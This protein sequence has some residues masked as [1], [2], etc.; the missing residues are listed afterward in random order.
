[1]ADDFAAG[2]HPHYAGVITI[3]APPGVKPRI[4]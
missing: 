4:S 1:M 2:H 3:P